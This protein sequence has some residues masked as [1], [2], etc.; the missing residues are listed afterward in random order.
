[1]IRDFILN[2]QLN[3]LCKKLISAFIIKNSSTRIYIWQT[4]FKCLYWY[5]IMAI[6]LKKMKPLFLILNSVLT[7]SPA[8]ILQNFLVLDLLLQFVHQVHQ[9]ITRVMSQ[10][11]KR[12]NLLL[13]LYHCRKNCLKSH[14]FKP[15]HT[16]ALTFN[17]SPILK[18]IL[19]LH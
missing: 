15:E 11:L 4:S 17:Q 6:I 5:R 16:S 3:S 19:L 8:C 9:L 12:G 7:E 10:L 2:I 14:I 1:M 13:C 18:M